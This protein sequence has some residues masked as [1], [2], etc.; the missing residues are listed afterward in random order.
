MIINEKTNSDEIIKNTKELINHIPCINIEYNE[1]G[2]NDNNFDKKNTSEYFLNLLQPYS[3]FNVSEKQLEVEKEKILDKIK[4]NWPWPVEAKIN[5]HYGDKNIYI[6]INDKLFKLSISKTNE[7]ILLIND[8]LNSTETIPRNTKFYYEPQLNYLDI[9]INKIR[10]IVRKNNINKIFE[11]IK[12][13]PD[14]N[15]ISIFSSDENYR[16]LEKRE[17]YLSPDEMLLNFYLMIN[18]SDIEYEY[19]QTKNYSDK[20][21]ENY[22]IKQYH[23]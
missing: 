5:V 6:T 10:I 22:L 11:Q 23:K 15:N 1:N 2:S 7:V 19:E 17:Y 12:N 4:D 18:L 16:K 21:I 14:F 13:N 20:D 3:E 8:L 9:N